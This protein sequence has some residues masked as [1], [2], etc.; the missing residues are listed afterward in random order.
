MP[1]P[2]DDGRD[3]VFA[4]WENGPLATAVETYQ[5]ER[6]HVFPTGKTKLPHDSI[7]TLCGYLKFRTSSRLQEFVNANETILNEYI[8]LTEPEVN[9]NISPQKQTTI[10]T[11]PQVF[12]LLTKAWSNVR[13][14]MPKDSPGFTLDNTEGLDPPISKVNL[15]P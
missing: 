7:E 2:V 4:K 13:K 10:V 6:I 14:L 9:Y 8:R 3:L 12:A 15:G 11:I 5:D 1:I